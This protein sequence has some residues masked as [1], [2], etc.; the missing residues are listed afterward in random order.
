MVSRGRH[1]SGGVEGYLVSACRYAWKHYDVGETDPGAGVALPAVKNA[2]KYYVTRAQMLAIAKACRCKSSRAAIRIAYY[3]GMRMSEIIRARRVGGDFVL[4]D[5]KNGDP[6]LIPIHPKIRACLGVPLKDRFW[7][8]KRFKEA[9]RLLGMGHLR[10][11]DLRHSA[12][13]AMINARVDLYTVG[14]VLGHKSATSTQRYAHLQ[15]ARL[16]EAVDKMGRKSPYTKNPKGGKAAA[17][18]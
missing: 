1:R 5:T 11:H 17:S 10:F 14:A 3:S 2:R 18:A 9:V 15:T 6:R 13:S 4:D 12:A 16:R 8:S 7:M